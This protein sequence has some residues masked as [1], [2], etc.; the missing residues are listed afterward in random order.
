VRLL[1]DWSFWKQLLARAFLFQCDCFGRTKPG[2]KKNL[3]ITIPLG[4]NNFSDHFVIQ[5][6]NFSRRLDASCVP[7][8][9]GSVH[10]DFHET[11]STARS[12][13]S[14]ARDGLVRDKYPQLLL[15]AGEPL[16]AVFSLYLALGNRLLQK[17]F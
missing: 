9:L 13:S 4:I 1:R 7:F 8:T 14:S 2:G 12:R 17:L 11:S 15:L 6:K 16:P 5:L 3:V 10:S